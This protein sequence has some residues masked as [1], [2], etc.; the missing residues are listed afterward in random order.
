MCLRQLPLLYFIYYFI[1]FLNLFIIPTLIL[2]LFY[3][4]V[5]YSTV[6]CYNV[7]KRLRQDMNKN[8]FQSN[9]DHPFYQACCQLNLF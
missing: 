9:F 6:F 7:D 8:L 5:I 4:T 3:F 2:I 1:I